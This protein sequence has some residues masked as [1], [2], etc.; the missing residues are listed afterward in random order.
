MNSRQTLYVLA[1]Q[2]VIA[3]AVVIVVCVLGVQGTLEGESVVAILSSALALAG[4]AAA[5]VSALGSAVNGKATIPAAEM[6]N[7][8]HTLRTAIAGASAAPA[9]DVG[10]EDTTGPDPAPPG[11]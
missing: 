1:M 11:Q 9:H 6:A 8:E 2:G 5:A 4:G 7:R 10:T 3:L